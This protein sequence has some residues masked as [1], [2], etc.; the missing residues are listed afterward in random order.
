MKYFV[1]VDGGGSKTDFAISTLDGI[2]LARYSTTGASYQML[3]FVDVATLIADGVNECLSILNVQLSDCAG[4]CIGLPCY[5]ENTQSD[6][7][8]TSLLRAA[9]EPMPLYIANDV[10]VGWAGSLECGEGIH[11]VAGTGAIAFARNAS[12]QTARSGGWIELFGDEGSCY[13]IG[14]EAMSLFTKQA[15][16]RIKQDALYTIVR[17]ALN[18]KNDYDFINIVLSEYAGHREQV[19]K[20]QLFA[21]M[22]AK[23]GDESAIALYEKAAVELAQLAYSLK[24]KLSF[25]ANVAV[26]YSGGLFKAG[27]LILKPL[28][29]KL[30]ECG[31]V[32]QP[33]KKTAIEGA[34]LLAIEYF[35]GRTS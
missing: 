35:D 9:L 20:F 25:T 10:E 22:A 33:P 19:A 14:R 4:C 8:I 18:I 7:H 24:A 11:I 13:W 17:K 21:E 3:G 27:E 23:E 1:G 26:S 30:E 34:L 32:L 2:P 29:S 5:G 28:C 31:C 12:K 16:A 15:D 6:Q